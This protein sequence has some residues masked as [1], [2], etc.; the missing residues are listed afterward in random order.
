VR[1]LLDTHVLIWYF[2]TDPKMSRRAL[3]LI[4]DPAN[5]K[6]VSP[7]TYWEIAIKL[8]TGKYLFAES[9]PDFVQH[10]I[11][12]NGFTILPVLPRHCEPLTSLPRHHN[13]PFDRLLISQAIVEAV[14]IVSADAVFD[15]YAVARMW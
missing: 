4:A 2:E 1:L 7:A 3:T 13:D 8:G 9:F 10:A 14:P 5:E 15:A 12:D 6:V 11:L